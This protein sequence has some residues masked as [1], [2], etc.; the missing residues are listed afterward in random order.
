MD[1]AVHYVWGLR[2]DDLVVFFAACGIADPA[3]Y[4]WTINKE[5]VTCWRCKQRT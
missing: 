5:L 3:A 2:Q 1:V 4:W